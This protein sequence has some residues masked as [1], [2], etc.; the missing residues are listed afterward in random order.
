[1]KKN[2]DKEKKKKKSS[3]KAALKRNP[4]KPF[5]EKEMNIVSPREFN[6]SAVGKLNKKHL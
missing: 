2:F 3:I 4:S 6:N 5:I 1:M